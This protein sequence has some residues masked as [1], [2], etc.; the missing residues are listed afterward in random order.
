MKTKNYQL[1]Q[2]YKTIKLQKLFKLKLLY[3]FLSYTKIIL[4]ILEQIITN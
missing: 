3:K 2:K 1:I 4:K